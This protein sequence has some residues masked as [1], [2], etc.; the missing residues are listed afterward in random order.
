M[1]EPA[2]DLRSADDPSTGESPNAALSRRGRLIVAV[3]SLV[4]VALVVAGVLLWIQVNDSSARDRERAAALAVAQQQAVLLTSVNPGN[5]D[6][7]VAKLLRHS[8]GEFRRQFEAAAPTFDRVITDGAVKS[9]GEVAGA[10]VVRMSDDR[11]RALVA[12]NS[13]VHNAETEKGEPRRY[14]LQVDLV[15]EA[16][17]WLVSNMRFVP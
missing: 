15:K 6:G 13:V 8:T 2:L 1:D 3:L 16:G 12:V 17:Q 11:V 14:R 5:V 10:G 7:Q 9:R 4:T